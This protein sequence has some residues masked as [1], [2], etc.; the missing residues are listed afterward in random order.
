M[1]VKINILNFF[2]NPIYQSPININNP[3]SVEEFKLVINLLPLKGN[4][5]YTNDGYKLKLK[6]ESFGSVTHGIHN[7]TAKDIEIHYPSEHTFGI[8]EIRSPLEVQ[9]IC[10]DMFG[11]TIAIAILFKLGS[12]DNDILTVL[13]FGV[14]N[15]LFALKLRNND[16]IDLD[17]L[18]FGNRLDFGQYINNMKHYVT[19]TGSLTSPP[20]KQN[21]QWFIML[22]KLT[23]SQNQLDYFP[24]LFGRVSN[25]RGLQALN[26][27][28][29]KII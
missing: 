9:I 13:G 5:T 1:Q 26:N 28:S 25:V 16:S 8:D 12:I 2:R 29:L 15:P 3:F 24:I 21:V 22:N 14:D 6:A 11:N 10:Q 4:I 18:K 23:V 27:R 19:Y 17:S 7:Y 20:C